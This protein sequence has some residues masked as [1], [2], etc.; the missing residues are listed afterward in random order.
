[1][2]NIKIKNCSLVYFKKNN[3]LIPALDFEI[4]RQRFLGS[5]EIDLYY[6]GVNFFGDKIGIENDEV[7]SDDEVKFYSDYIINYKN[8]MKCSEDITKALTYFYENKLCTTFFK[9]LAN[10]KDGYFA[11]DCT[12]DDWYGEYFETEKESLKWLNGIDR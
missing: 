4:E 3:S 11:I 7:L 6:D 8:Y 12:Y 5:D 1:M 9:F 2:K 10:T